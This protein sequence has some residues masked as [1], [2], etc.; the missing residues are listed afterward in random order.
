ML[1]AARVRGPDCESCEPLVWA[2]MMSPKLRRAILLFWLP[3]PY[4]VW[5]EYHPHSYKSDHAL[6]IF[7]VLVR[8]YRDHNI[9]RPLS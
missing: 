6:G 8:P 3:V 9:E 4:R 1:R 5:S 7:F 2:Q